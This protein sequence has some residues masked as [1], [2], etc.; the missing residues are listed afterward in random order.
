VAFCDNN[1][2]I[3][4]ILEPEREDILKKENFVGKR[5][6]FKFEG[7]TAQ[8]KFTLTLLRS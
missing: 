4:R 8:R 3:K 7:Q 1:V 6:K 5:K 2:G